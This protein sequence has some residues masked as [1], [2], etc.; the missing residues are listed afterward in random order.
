MY[1][2]SRRIPVHVLHLIETDA[3]RHGSVDE[4]VE[5]RHPDGLHHHF[6]VG[7]AGTNVSALELNTK[8][9]GATHE[10]QAEGH[11][12]TTMRYICG[13]QAHDDDEGGREGGEGKLRKSAPEIL[14]WHRF[15]PNGSLYILGAHLIYLYIFMYLCSVPMSAF[16]KRSILLPPVRIRGIGTAV[17]TL[18]VYLVYSLCTFLLRKIRPLAA[19]CKNNKI[20]LN[21]VGY[22]I[23]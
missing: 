12:Q 8:Y 6:D 19:S 10:V 14:F 23:F 2:R 3:V 18:F 9:Y 4:V 20:S 21:F 7:V 17:R 1:L 5:R 15:R 13:I 16:E 11:K 22:L